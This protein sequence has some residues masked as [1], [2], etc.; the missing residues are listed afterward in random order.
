MTM[1][2]DGERQSQAWREA[3]LVELRHYQ[4]QGRVGLIGG[5][6]HDA[7]IATEAVNSGL[8]D[9][10]RNVLFRGMFPINMLGHDDEGNRKLYQAC[11]ERPL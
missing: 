10:L 2:D 4:E 7:A 9:V 8:L 1:I 11:A 5:S 3:S 6:A